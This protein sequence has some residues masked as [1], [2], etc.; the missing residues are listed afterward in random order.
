MSTCDW[1]CTSKYD[2]LRPTAKIS[3]S[4][5]APIPPRLPVERPGFVD[6]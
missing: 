1:N 2:I 6:P 4:D 3:K 5:K